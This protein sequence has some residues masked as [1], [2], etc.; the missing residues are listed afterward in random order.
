M[1]FDTLKNCESYYGINK[2]MEKAFDFIKK[3]VSE[4]FPAGKYEIDGDNVYASVQ[5]YVTADEKEKKF[6]GHRKY[7]DIQY[8][9]SGVENM[10]VSDISKM[11]SMIAYSD[12]KDVEFYENTDSFINADVGDGEYAI[13]LP[14]DI[15]KPGLNSKSGANSIKKVLVK[16]RL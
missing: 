1:I 10:R 16:I 5:E 14:Q 3:A 4:N 13:F 11:K 12:E 8:I 15:H 9:V 6:E 7:L 2:N